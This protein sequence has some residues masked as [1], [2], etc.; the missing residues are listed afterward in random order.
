MKT[1]TH[2]RVELVRALLSDVDSAHAI[3]ASDIAGRFDWFFTDALLAAFI[4]TGSG[5]AKKRLRA[6]A[7]NVGVEYVFYC[8]D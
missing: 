2:E 1:Q 4:L 8:K 5:Q 3:S 7:K 6:D